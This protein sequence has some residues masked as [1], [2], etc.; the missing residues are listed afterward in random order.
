MYILYRLAE[1]LVSFPMIHIATVTPQDS[2]MICE[3]LHAGQKTCVNLDECKDY[4]DFLH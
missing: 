2:L 4:C 3:K 1:Y